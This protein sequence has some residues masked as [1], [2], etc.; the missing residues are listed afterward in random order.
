MFVIQWLANSAADRAFWAALSFG[1]RRFDNILIFVLI[2][3]AALARRP[4]WRLLMAACAIWT[5][6][7]FCA[8][9]LVDLNAYQ[10]LSELLVVIPRG[11]ERGLTVLMFIPPAMRGGSALTLI[12]ALAAS[13]AAVGVVLAVPSR[14]RAAAVSLYLAAMTA[15][16]AWAGANGAARIEQYRPLIERSRAFA[17]VAGNEIGE[18]NLYENEIRYLRKSGRHAEADRTAE[19][20]RAVMERRREALRA[21]GMRR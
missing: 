3:A 1:A 14:L 7:L 12:L 16:M 2:G 10:T 21:A 5:M 15:L 20:L 19:E 11:L 13:A 18:Q 8:A 4:L 9:R 6:L 17:A